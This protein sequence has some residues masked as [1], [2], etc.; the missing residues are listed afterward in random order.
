MK[1]KKGR[2]LYLKER[3]FENLIN[4]KEQKKRLEPKNFFFKIDPRPIHDKKFISFCLKEIRI[5]LNQSAYKLYVPRKKFFPL[6]NKDFFQIIYFL[7]KKLDK[8][9]KI[10]NK[11]EEDIPKIFKIIGYPIALTKTTLFCTNSLQ[12]SSV[13][14]N[15]LYWLVELC[16]YD[17]KTTFENDLIN[18]IFLK[19]NLFWNRF[20]K[21]HIKLLLKEGK[22]NFFP[23]IAKLSLSNK[24]NERKNYRDRKIELNRKIKFKND[25]FIILLHISI[26]FKEKIKPFFESKN[27]FINLMKILEINRYKFFNE[28]ENR[29]NIT[30]RIN[31]NRKKNLYLKFE[32]K[33]T[34]YFNFLNHY[35]KIIYNIKRS[36]ICLA[37]LLKLIL[38]GLFNSIDIIFISKTSNFF[39]NKN[40][41]D[42]IYLNLFENINKKNFRLECKLFFFLIDFKFFSKI[43]NIY[44][45]KILKILKFFEHFEIFSNLLRQNKFELE[46]IF[47]I[48]KFKKYN[49]ERFKNE[50]I[51]KSQENKFFIKQN[52]KKTRSELFYI[53]FKKF[54]RSFYL[55]KFIFLNVV[56]RFLGKVIIYINLFFHF[57]KRFD[58]K[59][60]LINWF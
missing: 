11:P 23:K 52:F 43:Q 6:K 7:I 13:L 57:K 26:F 49:I 34:T 24:I 40:Y 19:K 9:F 16:L 10:D 53:I 17:L 42:T 18:K 31:L 51:E 33:K 46:I 12:G 50:K 35:S 47:Q 15:C 38:I 4:K 22:T 44:K 32:S 45:N 28:I 27:F 30:Q 48:W 37:V 3:N 5:F 56:K 14:F 20:V 29:L 8:N 2:I 21:S 60:K 25:F 1:V 41:L 36:R 55:K 54:F 59:E 39:T 58:K